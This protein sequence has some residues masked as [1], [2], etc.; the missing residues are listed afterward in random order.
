LIPPLRTGPPLSLLPS[1]ARCRHHLRAALDRATDHATSATF[2]AARDLA[3]RGRD[4]L[5]V[6]RVHHPAPSDADN[7]PTAASG[8]SLTPVAPWAVAG[9]VYEGILDAHQPPFLVP[10]PRDAPSPLVAQRLA[11]SCPHSSGRDRRR[12]LDQHAVRMRGR[13][14]ARTRDVAVHRLRTRDTRRVRRPRA[15]R[16]ASGDGRGPQIKPARLLGA[17]RGSVRPS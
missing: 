17:H 8:L 15:R 11:N 12:Q 6:L 7:K 13:A 2:H 4:A 14:H 5:A 1:A 16:L 10:R 3:W 9:H